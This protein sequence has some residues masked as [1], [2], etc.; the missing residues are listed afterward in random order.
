MTC[1]FAQTQ[2]DIDTLQTVEAF[3]YA[4]QL[5][6]RKGPRLFKPAGQWIAKDPAALP[7]QTYTHIP[8]HTLS[9]HL[10]KETLFVDPAQ[11]F[12]SQGQIF[13]RFQ[14][15]IQNLSL[16][17]PDATAPLSDHLLP[18]CDKLG[19]V[20]TARLLAVAG[21]D[22]LRYETGLYLVNPQAVL[23]AR[24]DGRFLGQSAEP[25]LDASRPQDET[26]LPTTQEE[27]HRDFAFQTAFP[28]SCG[29][30]HLYESKGFPSLRL[31]AKS[32]ENAFAT[33]ETFVAY[34]VADCLGAPVPAVRLCLDDKNA[35]LVFCTYIEGASL[36]EIHRT[37]CSAYDAFD[38]EQRLEIGALAWAF[39]DFSDPNQG[40]FV[41]HSRKGAP[42]VIDAG[43]ALRCNAWGSLKTGAIQ[44]ESDWEAPHPTDALFFRRKLRTPLAA[45]F[46]AR[47]RTLES[48]EQRRHNLPSA[49]QAVAREIAVW[50]PRLPPHIG[51]H[52]SRHALDQE[53]LAPLERRIGNG[54]A[55]LKHQARIAQRFLNPK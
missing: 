39:M 26:H 15:L 51:A 55:L 20:A 11:A 12:G 53:I 18:L 8:T 10:T 25:L 28:V 40:N 36:T 4:P 47:A 7:R 23:E 6:S 35:P 5:C 45:S 48:I 9:L 33:L 3:L 19:D 27:L 54:G 49:L 43:G 30:A 1:Y 22:G 13:A 24:V 29:F 41:F 21:I 16:S 37:A 2:E 46:E 42:F 50:I 31:V 38:L 14:D 32:E 17:P 44:G 34:R 52:F